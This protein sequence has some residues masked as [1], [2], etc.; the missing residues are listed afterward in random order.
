MA[1]RPPTQRFRQIPFSQVQNYDRVPEIETALVSLQQGNFRQASILSDAMLRDDRLWGVLDTRVGAIKAA[2]VEV[3]PANDRRAAEKVATALGG[4]D[5]ETGCWNRLF[6]PAIAAEMLASG[7]MTGIAVG[8]LVWQTSLD[9]W[10]PR[11]VPWH[12]QFV[13]WDWG[14]WSYKLITADGILELPKVNENVNSD[15]KWFIWFPFG[16]QYAWRRAMVKPLADLYLARRW[17]FRDWARFNEKYGQPVDVL[18]V[19]ANADEAIKEATF[20]AIQNRGSDTAVMIPKRENQ[21]ADDGWDLDILEAG[22]GGGSGFNSF[23][24]WLAEL[25]DSIAI[26][27]LGQNLTTQISKGAGSKAAA[28]VHDQVRLDKKLEDAGIAPSFRDQVLHW[29]AK[30][31][32]GDED[33]A[34]RVRYVVEPAEDLGQKGAGLLAVGQAATALRQGNPRAD[35]DAIYDE[36]GIPL[37]PIEVVQQEAED[38]AKRAAAAGLPPPGTPPGGAAPPAGGKPTKGKPGAK[39]KGEEK[40]PTHA[41]EKKPPVQATLKNTGEGVVKRYSFQGLAVAIENPAG[42]VRHWHD[43]DGNETGSTKM[44][45]DYGYLED[46]VGSDGEELDC[47]V[48]PESKAEHVHVVHQLRAP[49]FKAHDEDKVMLGFMTADGAKGAYLAHRNDGDRAFGSM[50]TFKL[51]DFKDKLRR[52]KGKGKIHATAALTSRVRTVTRKPQPS[53]LYSDAVADHGKAAGA[54]A[55][56]VDLH[57]VRSAIASATS[58]EDAKARL[59][60]VFKQMHPEA[61][62]KVVEKARIMAKAGG[63]DTGWQQV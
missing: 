44:L 19:P 12:S 56:H 9:E 2:E 17:D 45:H 3:K 13:Y 21:T 46:Y 24:L 10:I 29:W 49:E 35:I 34:P 25:N 55:L 37:R 50:T 42:S 28:Q 61:F 14:S 47:Y 5:S 52:R 43:A 59:A 6:P 22:S 58:W 62:A 23:K 32:Y 48:G 8:E 39:A 7:M 31:N 11:V 60:Q 38:A 57:H 18:S 51:E 30:F 16:Y 40:A 4:D 27:V 54:R 1:A 26:T 15:G 63:M 53:K 41:D 33:L 36:V 20:A